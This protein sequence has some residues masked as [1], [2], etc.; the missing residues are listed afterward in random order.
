MRYWILA[1]GDKGDQSKE[2]FGDKVVRITGRNELGNLS[3][4]ASPN[5][6]AQALRGK[7]REEFKTKNPSN[8]A[9][10][11]FNFAHEIKV[12]DG[13]FLRHGRNTLLGYG[14]A[15]APP[16]RK[17]LSGEATAY[18]FDNKSHPYHHTI[19][20]HWLKKGK[21]FFKSLFPQNF[22]APRIDNEATAYLRAMGLVSGPNLI[23]PGQGDDVPFDP[24]GIGDARERISRTIAQRRGQKSFRDALIAAYGGRCAITGC[25]VLDVL[26]AAHIYPYRG[27]KTNKV[28][29][30]LLLRADL[31][32]LFDCGLIDINPVT[33]KVMLVPELHSSEYG[34]LHGRTLRTPKSQS[35]APSREA[36]QS[37]RTEPP[38]PHA[39]LR[40][41]LQSA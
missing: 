26:E 33:L 10:L 22:I 39:Q 1:D 27:P 11:C 3:R 36:L 19:K 16:G 14:V 18:F 4:Y 25:N 8:K 7:Y 31:H 32:T 20:V 12:G 5:A 34:A 35:Q 15:S 17:S 38:L 28:T 30:G 21:F 9:T 41:K 23:E 13:L 24:K 40:A 37:R 29:N 2:F 6:V